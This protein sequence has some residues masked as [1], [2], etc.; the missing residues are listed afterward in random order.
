[1]CGQV[2]K[3]RRALPLS[4]SQPWSPVP[5]VHLPV[6][7]GSVEVAECLNRGEAVLIHCSDGWD[8][9]S[10]LS[11]LGQLFLDPY[12]RTFKG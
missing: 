7:Q 2:S 12:F 5:Y 3:Y 8:R 10:Q 6:L 11:S 4:T 9:T 1:M